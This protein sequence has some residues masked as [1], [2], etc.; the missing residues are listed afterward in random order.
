[1]LREDE[2]D[3]LLQTQPERIERMTDG[4]VRLTVHSP[5]GGPRV[6]TGSHVLVATGR[7][8]NTERLNLAAAGV[9]T[10]AQGFVRVNERLETGVPGIYCLGDAKGGPA[11]THISY[12]DFRIIETNL[13]KGGRATTQ[14]RLVPYCVFTDPE[15]G[16]VGLS[17]MEARS[18]GRT[19][20][21]YKM[22]MRSVAR[23]AEMDEPRG[24]MKAIVD[25]RSGEIL[26]CAILGIAGG[27]LMSAVEIAMMGHL[28]YTRLR[29]AIF[30]HPTLAEALNNL[31]DQ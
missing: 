8:P 7:V 4:T 22:P 28:P 26:G 16:R 29:D 24:L 12:D 27:E 19:I 20:Q 23:A 30:A 9:E 15:L 1:V 31:F 21:V 17:E 10:D 2:M 25:A 3:V 11:F 14:D 13:L 5:E 18:Q 6:L